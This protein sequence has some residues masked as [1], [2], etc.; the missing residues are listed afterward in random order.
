MPNLQSITVMRLLPIMLP[1]ILPIMLFQ[2]A[3]LLLCACFCQTSTAPSVRKC[4]VLSFD[5]RTQT[6][7]VT[8]LFNRGTYLF[9]LDLF[10]TSLFKMA[11][12]RLRCNHGTSLLLCKALL[13]LPPHLQML[14]NPHSVTGNT[15]ILLLL[16]LTYT[17]CMTGDTCVFFP[18]E[19][20]EGMFAPQ[21]VSFDPQEES[22][23]I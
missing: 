15:S 10:S 18:F 4:P 12:K 11:S 19:N 21:G 8:I 20:T 13:A 5:K 23:Q 3:S 6:K 2:D 9:S 14:A 22:L 17:L 7:L 1:I 16:M